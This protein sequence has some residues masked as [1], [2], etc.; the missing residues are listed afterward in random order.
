[1]INTTFFFLSIWYLALMGLA[2][3]LA[4]NSRESFFFFHKMHNNMEIEM[5]NNFT[6]KNYDDGRPLQWLQWVGVKIGQ[7]LVGLSLARITINKPKPYLLSVKNNLSRPEPCLHKGLTWPGSLYARL[8]LIKYIKGLKVYV[9][10]VKDQ[11]SKTDSL[12][13]EGNWGSRNVSKL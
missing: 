2:N 3:I 1:M 7:A 13:K 11:E 8:G 6:T 5:N 10:H 4:V 12:L 9:S